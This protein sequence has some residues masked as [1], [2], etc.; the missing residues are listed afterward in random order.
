M[1]YNILMPEQVGEIILPFDDDYRQECIKKVRE[2]IIGKNLSNISGHRTD[3]NLEDELFIPLIKEVIEAFRGKMFPAVEEWAVMN[4]WGAIYES[5]D[6]CTSHQ[7]LPAKMSFV[8]YL[9]VDKYSAPLVFDNC[10]L[11]ITPKNWL[12]AYFPAYVPHSVPTQMG[13]E[14][15][16]ILAGNLIAKD[17]VDD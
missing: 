17:Q 9:D 15:R 14:D 10:G 5:G 3:W 12:C 8:V 2:S 6:Y 1:I 4:F 16:I 13:G 11:S 7:H